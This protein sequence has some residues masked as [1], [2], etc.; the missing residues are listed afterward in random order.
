ML[1]LIRDIITLIQHN[2]FPLT[3]DTLKIASK[4]ALRQF[5][6]RI[7]QMRI[8]RDVSLKFREQLAILPNL[9]GVYFR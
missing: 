3:K 6:A 4:T 1:R 5:S 7:N 8:F 2:F 9:G